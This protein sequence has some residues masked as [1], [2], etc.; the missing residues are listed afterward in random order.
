MPVEPLVQESTRDTPSVGVTE[1]PER[2]GR[3]DLQTHQRLTHRASSVTMGA[4]LSYPSHGWPG[5]EARSPATR[6]S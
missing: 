3:S 6:Y 1:V 2:I 5:E 4:R